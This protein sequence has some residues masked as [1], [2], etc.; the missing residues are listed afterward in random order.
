MVDGAAGR[1]LGKRQP[2]RSGDWQ[3]RERFRVHED[4]HRLDGHDDLARGG[5][6]KIGAEC[7]GSLAETDRSHRELQHLIEARGRLPLDRLLDE[8]KI[9]RAR[10]ELIVDAGRASDKTGQH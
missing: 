6:A 2:D 7:E 8:L 4:V 9:Q 10:D 3:F 5:D 1:T